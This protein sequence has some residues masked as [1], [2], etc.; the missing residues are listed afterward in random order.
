MCIKLSDPFS[1]VVIHK[2]GG[3]VKN[4]KKGFAA[5]LGNPLPEIGKIILRVV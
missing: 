5:P 1:K 2:T 4:E 3:G